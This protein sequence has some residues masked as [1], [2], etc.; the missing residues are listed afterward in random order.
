MGVYSELVQR[1]WVLLLERDTLGEGVIVTGHWAVAVPQLALT[2]AMVMVP[3]A[4]GMPVISPVC[5]L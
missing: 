4:S 5:G 1:F 2:V 3:A